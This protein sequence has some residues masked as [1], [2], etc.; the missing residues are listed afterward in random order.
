MKNLQFY[1]KIFMQTAVAACFLCQCNSVTT[2]NKPKQSIKINIEKEPQTMDPRYAY[3][4]NDIN[5][6]RIFWDG[7][8]RVAGDG[9]LTTAIA[10]NYTISQ[11][12]KIYSFKLKNTQWSNG[13]Q[14]TAND[15]IYSWKKT[16]SPDSHSKHSSLLY[17]IKNG[18]H[19]NEGNLPMSMLGIHSD[20]DYTL[21]IEL[22]NPTPYFLELL[23][24]PVYYP[25]N[26][27][28]DF[29]NPDWFKDSSTYISSGPFAISDWKSNDH[30]IAKKNLF[31]W[32]N[33]VVKLNKIEMIMVDSETGHSMF[34]NNKLDW[35]G[36]IYPMAS[37]SLINTHTISN[38]QERP[39]YLKY[40]DTV[41][42]ATTPQ[43]Y[44]IHLQNNKLKGVTATDSGVIDFKTAY[45]DI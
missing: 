10:E 28:V 35:Q 29:E 4:I 33:N 3:T 44:V 30:I 15:F 20:D 41:S 2:K 39:D 22:E 16:L 8:M 25:I 1:A 42:S 6:M 31:Y 32:D 37:N 11:D 45:I 38:N 36:S 27:K 40:I 24:M 26:K 21:T 14:I 9:L 12:E 18:K 17:A 19:I 34:E 43:N 13:D 23:A 7:L 5:L